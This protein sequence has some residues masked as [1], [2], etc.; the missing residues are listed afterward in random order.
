MLQFDRVLGADGRPWDRGRRGVAFYAEHCARTILSLRSICVHWPRQGDSTKC[1]RVQESLSRAFQPCTY[2]DWLTT[3]L[4]E[5]FFDATER[6][7][8]TS[9]AAMLSR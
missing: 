2:E 7:I 8:R 3:V 9:A 4:D 1:W 6:K 5:V